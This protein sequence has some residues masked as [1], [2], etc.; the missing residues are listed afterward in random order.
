M[1][2]PAAAV[3]LGL[4]Q[5]PDLAIGLIHEDEQL[6]ICGGG[7]H[8]PMIAAHPGFAQRSARPEDQGGK[9]AASRLDQVSVALPQRARTPR[10]SRMAGNTSLFQSPPWAS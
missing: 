6:G 2:H 9:A 1:Q 3:A 5:L 8:P 7:I 10:R 4:A